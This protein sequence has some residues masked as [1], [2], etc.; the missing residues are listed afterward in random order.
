[1]NNEKAIF[2]GTDL[3]RFEQREQRQSLLWLCRVAIND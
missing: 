3:Q 1:M 2:A